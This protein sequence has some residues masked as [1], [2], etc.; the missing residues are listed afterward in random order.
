MMEPR[1]IAT[2]VDWLFAPQWLTVPEACRLSGWDRAA[3]LEIIDEG[4]V[5][6]DDRG[7]IE[8]ESLKEFNETLA[9]V[10]HWDEGQTVTEP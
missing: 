1:R 6:L 7:L 2:L 9:L 4:G 3:M 5:D 8:K 10:L